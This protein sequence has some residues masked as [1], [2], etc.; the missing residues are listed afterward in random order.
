MSSAVASDACDAA[1][2]HDQLY[3]LCKCGV[4]HRVE[5][6]ENDTLHSRG[7]AQLDFYPKTFSWIFSMQ[8]PIDRLTRGLPRK[9][10]LCGISSP[11][12]PLQSASISTFVNKEQVSDYLTSPICR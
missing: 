2:S 1:A 11:F 5:A 10:I 4:S 7:T 3:T 9:V 6:G 8:K 12:L